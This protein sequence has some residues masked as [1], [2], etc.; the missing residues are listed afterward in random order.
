[1]TVM[2]MHAGLVMP[3]VQ[4]QDRVQ[5]AAMVT[6]VQN[7]KF[8]MMGT[9]PIATVAAMPVTEWTTFAAMA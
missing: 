2:P 4:A 3:I 9:K 1:M 6:S 8:V 5:H 7:L